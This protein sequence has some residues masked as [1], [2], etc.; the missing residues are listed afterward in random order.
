[1]LYERHK[2]WSVLLRLFHW[3]SPRSPASGEIS[4]DDF[5]SLEGPGRCAGPRAIQFPLLLFVDSHVQIL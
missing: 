4:R 3:G 5:I 2:V 1:M